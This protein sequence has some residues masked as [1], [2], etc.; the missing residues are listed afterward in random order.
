MEKLPEWKY[1]HDMNTGMAEKLRVRAH[2][3]ATSTFISTYTPFLV[4]P[5]ST[6]GWIGSSI[7]EKSASD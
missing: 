3:Y 6:L 4:F 1:T 2:M 7:V 5:L